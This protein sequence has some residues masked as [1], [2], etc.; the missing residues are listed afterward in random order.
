[1][2]MVC[3]WRSAFRPFILKGIEMEQ[4]VIYYEDELNDEF[5]PGGITPRRIDASYK[6]EG[7]VFRPLL[8]AVLYHIV[9]K[10]LAF[11]YTKLVWGH[12]IVGR[13]KFKTVK[14]TAFFVYG[15]HTN[16]IGD[17]LVPSMMNFFGSTYVIVHPDNVSIPF[18]GRI[19]PALGAIPLPDDK[20]AFRNY[21]KYLDLLVKKKRMIAIYPEAH[22]WPYYTHIRPFRA[23]SFHYPVSYGVP[24]F[25]FTNTYHKRR[26][27]K[28]PR[29]ITRIEGP[30]YP[31]TSLKRNEAIK[32]LRDRI[33]AAMD[34]NTKYNDIEMIR[35]IKK[36]EKANEE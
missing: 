33:Y 31:D 18:L 22:I 21:R 12:K 30:F 25:C 28:K 27:R 16:Q 19:T 20:D 36:T 1:M 17:P 10:I 32:D 24:S 9:A 11:L 7:T 34:E 15:N 13:K 6:Y 23:E 35:Y 14:D 5:S 29:M 2:L 3:T 26:F 4:S 8:R